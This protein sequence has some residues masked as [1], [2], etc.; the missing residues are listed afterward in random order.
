M[1][2]VGWGVVR[3]RSRRAASDAAAAARERDAIAGPNDGASA[4]AGGGAHMAEIPELLRGARGN[5]GPLIA[6]FASWSG[7]PAALFA[8]RI[9]LGALAA[10][11]QPLVR[12]AALLAAVQ[13]SPLSPADDPLRREIVAA[14]SGVWSNQTVRKGRDLIFAESRPK[15]REVVIAS[16]VDLALSDRGA[17]LDPA[18]RY[19]IT[20]DFIDLYRQAS[21]AGRRDIVAVVRKLG[22]NDTAELLQGNGLGADSPLETHAQY[23]RALEAAQKSAKEM[24]VP[25]AGRP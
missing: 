15:A 16:F 13:A 8:R 12:L 21:P 4:T 6:A 25:K 20:S 24:P 2:L 1:P 14:V 11:P 23:R 10:E 3:Y 5:P 7:D 19:G 22:S 18:Q 9:V 17:A